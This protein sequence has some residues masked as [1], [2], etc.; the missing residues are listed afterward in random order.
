M[1]N[2]GIKFKSFAGYKKFYAQLPN[3][4]GDYRT[5]RYAHTFFPR[6]VWFRAFIEKHGLGSVFDIGCHTGIM[7]LNL[8]QLG[9]PVTG[10]DINK[11]AIDK[12]KEFCEDF[13]IKNCKFKVSSFEEYKKNDLFDYVLISEIIEHVLDPIAL[14]EFAEKHCK[15]AVIITTPSHDGVFGFKQCNNREHLR[16]Y[17]PSELKKLIS[18]RGKVIEFKHDDII[19]LAYKPCIK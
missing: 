18:K 7:S 1:S 11:G 9:V 6:A 19:Y 2:V 14:L 3:A 15:K 12:C 4:G 17:K 8:T 5:L 10:I 13:G 16:S